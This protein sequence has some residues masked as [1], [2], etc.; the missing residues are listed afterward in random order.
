M[1]YGMFL[2]GGYKCQNHFQSATALWLASSFSCAVFN[3]WFVDFVVGLTDCATHRTVT[4][5]DVWGWL[6]HHHGQVLYP[7]LLTWLCIAVILGIVFFDNQINSLFWLSKM[8]ASAFLL[9][10]FDLSMLPS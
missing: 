8:F 5:F 9:P 10:G 4:V 7:A 3:E 6:P 1:S 2:A